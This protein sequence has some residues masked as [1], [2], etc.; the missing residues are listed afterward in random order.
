MEGED[1]GV[2][3]P[4]AGGLSAAARRRMRPLALVAGGVAILLLIVVVAGRVGSG[5]GALA[6]LM[7]LAV[8][9]DGHV[10]QGEECDDGNARTDDACLPSCR[11]ARCGDGFV[12]AHVEECDDGNHTDGDGCSQ[13]CLACPP[14]ATQFAWASNGHCYWRVDAPADWES[15]AA[16]CATS[17]GHLAVYADDHEWSA[18]TERLLR[19]TT[20]SVWMG[21][22]KHERNGLRDF[23]WESGERLLSV[24]WTIHEP[25]RVPPDLDCAAEAESGSWSAESC[26]DR[27]PF[28]CERPTWTVRPQSN[29]AYRRYVGPVRWPEARDFCASQGGHLVTLADPEEQAFVTSRFQGTFWVGATRAERG[30]GYRWVTGEPLRYLDFAP[31]EPDFPDDQR[32]LAMDVD[33]RWYSR[34]CRSR[35]GFVCEIE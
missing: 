24:H 8:C 2:S 35:Y 19:G 3:S 18:V 16:S 31:G 17:G 12:R 11:R 34:V 30:E 7:G 22:R 1:S 15:A 32:C 13:G 26:S 10:D 27:R 25:R 29:N 28:L 33:R 5:G 9:G 20:G 4:S 14:S 21:L 23:E 6:R